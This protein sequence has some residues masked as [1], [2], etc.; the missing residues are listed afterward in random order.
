MRS[1]DPAG[2]DLYVTLEPC[3]HF[4][5]TPPCTRAILEAGIRRVVIG[6]P[7]PNPDVTGGG[8]A[9]LRQNG[10]SVLVGV[11]EQECR[12]A[13]A[14][15]TVWKT[16]ARPF[17]TV[18]L[19]MTMDGRIATRNG[20]S[21]WVSGEA[22]RRRVHEM[23]ACVQ[24]VLIGGGTLW[25]DNPRLT[26]RLVVGPL[27]GNPQPLAVL[28][29][30]RPP[31][32]DAPLEILRERPEQCIILTGAAWAASKTAD[33]LTSLGVRVW[34]LP[35]AGDDCLDLLPGLERLYRETH[36]YGLL[37]EGGSS[38]AGSLLNQSLMDE[39]VVF[40]APKLL[41]DAEAVSGFSGLATPCMADAARLRFIDARRVGEDLMLVARPVG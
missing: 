10:L 23:R 26:H 16:C 6:C 38:L 34:G 36:V 14:D 37:C 41:G 13:I 7:D 19:A 22:S 35:E 12:D 21:S 31:A 33:A 17:V 28:V 24:A 11:L 15:F 25:A 3:N 1:I 8:A 18:K 4:G 40:Q 20:D 2:C 27:A 32:H 29:T 39:L 9:F 5:K 30:R